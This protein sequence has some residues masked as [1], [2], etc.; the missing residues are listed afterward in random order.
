MSHRELLAIRER[1]RVL[2]VQERR[3]LEFFISQAIS[4]DQYA[5]TLVG[6]KPVSICNVIVED[7]EDLL[8]FFRESFQTTK[9]QTLRRGYLVWQKYQ[10]LFPMKQRVLVDYAF[11]GR[12]RREI[13]LICH[14][15]C[16]RVIQEHLGD[17]QD[18]L[19]KLYT[20]EEVFEIL[21]HPKHE[22]FHKIIDHTRLIGILLGF[23]KGNAALYEQH[24][25]GV[26]RSAIWYEH[27]AQDPLQM[28][29]DEWP[30]P[31]A[32]LSPDFACDPTTE[33]TKQLRKHYQKASKVVYWTYFLR[34]S[35]E[36]TLALLVQN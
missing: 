14:S 11:L 25:G 32:Q 7:T 20:S 19:G 4:L 22:D 34:N 23:G 3:D 1:L 35:L 36:V 10:S 6:Y 29:S 27:S 16:T 13:A 15:L 33:E 9:Y 17:F 30:W 31:W 26:S 21:T 2:T 5:Y 18:V 12:G 28:F 24:R 8:P